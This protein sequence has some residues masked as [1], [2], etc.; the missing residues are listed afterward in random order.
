MSTTNDESPNNGNQE[1]TPTNNQT[2][3]DTD[4]SR[5]VSFL[6]DP[7]IP[8][9]L[10][11]KLKSIIEQVEK[12]RQ[13]IGDVA[14]KTNVVGDSDTVESSLTSDGGVLPSL[15][16]KGMRNVFSVYKFIVPREKVCTLRSAIV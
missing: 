2:H 4:E 10:K 7:N 5:L 16:N 15:Y 13:A 1:S 14:K 8:S 9:E 6:D 12:K 11:R 3:G